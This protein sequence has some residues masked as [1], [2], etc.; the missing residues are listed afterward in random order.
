[1]VGAAL[2]RSTCWMPDAEFRAGRSRV[3]QVPSCWTRK[4][5]NSISCTLLAEC[6]I[7]LLSR[8]MPVSSAGARQGDQGPGAGCCPPSTHT[9]V[10][11]AIS[12]ASSTSMPG[13][14]TVHSSLWTSGHRVATAVYVG[15]PAG[16]F[17]P[18]VAVPDPDLKLE[19]S[20]REP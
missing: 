2:C 18:P 16:S 5:M 6:A 13:H 17:R 19:Y 15:F 12:S 4:Y 10:C 20:D 7:E 3:R 9:S 14:R 11:S 1:M 8:R